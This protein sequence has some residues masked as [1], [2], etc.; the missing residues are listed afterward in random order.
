MQNEKVIEVLEEGSEVWAMDLRGIGELRHPSSNQQLG[1]WKTFFLAYLLD[2]S[3]V[4][5]RTE[6]VLVCARLMQTEL[7]GKALKIRLVANGEATVTAAHALVVEPEL[8]GKFSLGNLTSWIV[9]CK[10][11]NREGQLTNAIHSVLRHYDLPYL[12]RLGG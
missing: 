2:Q 9:I 7:S 11:P 5:P 10:D 4:G 12:L 8:L 6:D 1:D 3:L